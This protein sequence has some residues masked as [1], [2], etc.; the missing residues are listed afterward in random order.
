MKIKLA[1][2]FVIM[3][4]NN[5][6]FSQSYIIE[7][8]FVELSGN[9]SNS[10]FSNNTYYSAIDSCRVN[11]RVISESIPNGWTFSFCF[12][13]CYEPGVNEGSSLFIEN[14]QKY[15]NCHIYPN[16]TPGTG[17]IEMEITTNET[18][19]DTVVWS[20]VA[21]DNLSANEMTLKP[22]GNIVS[23]FNVEGKRMLTPTRNQICF[24]EYENGEV[25]KLIHIK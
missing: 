5:P 22:R 9:A 16:N 19:K 1:L 13:N 21:F 6:L 25:I 2:L 15:L 3:F 11:W 17:V 18:Y 14:S 23:I 7:D 8:L 10:D 12:P 4:F 24:I 20:A